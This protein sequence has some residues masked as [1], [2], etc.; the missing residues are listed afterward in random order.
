MINLAIGRTEKKVVIENTEYLLAFDNISIRV[1]KELYKV[2][3]MQT[4][5][6]LGEWD[7][8]AIINFATACIREI[9]DPD[10]PL[11]VE[12][13]QRHDLISILLGCGSAV[14]EMVISG[15]PQKVEKK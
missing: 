14:V 1:Y 7:D 9:D 3:F 2:S 5:N 8:V 4:F 13:L 11:G 6:L 10:K 12:L 15:L